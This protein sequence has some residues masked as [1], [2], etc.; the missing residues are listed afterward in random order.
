[1]SAFVEQTMGRVRA[2]HPREEEFHQAVH[3]VAES[4][5]LVVE[6]RPQY[7]QAKVMERLL[8]PQRIT[9]FRVAWVDD[10]GEVQVNRGYLVQ[11][12]NALGPFKGGIRFHPSVDLGVIKFLAF[13]QT[14]KNA[15][16]TLP[17]GGG[18]A[19][20]DFDPK[21]KSDL[22]VMRFCQAFMTEQ[23]RHMGAS[24]YVPAGDIGV[25]A[26]ELGFLFGQYKRLTDRFDGA[27]TGKAPGWGGSLLRPEATGYGLA[28]FAEE[29]LHARQEEF[30]DKVCLVSGSGNVAQHAV[31]KLIQLGAKPVTMSD[32]SG[33]IHD[34]AGID[35]DKL[36]FVKDLKNVR[37]GRIKEY[38]DRYSGVEYT[39]AQ[40]YPDHHPMWAMNADC[41]FPCATQ[42]EITA[43]DA[44]KLVEAGVTLVAEGANM[45]TTADAVATLQGAGVAFAPGKASNAGGVAVSGLEMAQNGQRVQWSRN[46]V[47]SRLHGIM[48]EIHATCV[49]RA[50]E[51]DVPG[52]YVHGANVGGFVR[53]ADAML[54]Q[55]VV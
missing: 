8:E 30:D 26:R 24:T 6:R 20:S 27:L 41:A 39:S 34:P 7:A 17:L 15:L 55:G 35:E 10:A 46:K 45:P 22:E 42:N 13:E 37:R 49:W 51:Y 36:A 38:A 11:H 25:G 19:G 18:K 21:G 28:Y 3:E 48:K 50:D 43:V 5:A 4:A 47:D 54:D 23:H 16:T 31:E 9:I 33:F 29:M 53:V 12:N 52:N 2:T 32:S 40:D 1:M 14:F 44:Q